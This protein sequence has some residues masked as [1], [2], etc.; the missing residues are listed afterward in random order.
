MC[1][2]TS[3]SPRC[4]PAS[5]EQTA[6]SRWTA[7]PSVTRSPCP[8]R[9]IPLRGQPGQD[10]LAILGPEVARSGGNDDTRGDLHRNGCRSG[11]TAA[12]IVIVTGR[13]VAAVSTLEAAATTTSATASVHPETAE[14]AVRPI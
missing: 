4:G 3:R 9:R 8:D 1:E 10:H 5:S 12:A 13:A 2:P 11:P 14:A 7:R 6:P